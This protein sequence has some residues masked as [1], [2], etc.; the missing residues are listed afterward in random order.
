[1][2]VTII[3]TVDVKTDN[4]TKVMDTIKDAV[5]DSI[6]T[7]VGSNDTCV[8]IDLIVDNKKDYSTIL[9]RHLNQ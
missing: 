6:A 1:M 9:D 8:S 7:L 5:S 3:V 2:K 4:K